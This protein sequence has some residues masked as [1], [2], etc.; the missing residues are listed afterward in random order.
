MFLNILFIF[1][2][3]YKKKTLCLKNFNTL[4][5]EREREREKE[6]VEREREKERAER[7]GEFEYPVQCKKIFQLKIPSKNILLILFFKS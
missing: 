7:E 4:S 2:F 5:S 3:L 6:R 1:N